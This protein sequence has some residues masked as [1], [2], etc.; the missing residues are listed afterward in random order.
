MCH[1]RNTLN[2]LRN[3]ST[4]RK[5]YTFSLNKKKKRKK[6]NLKLMFQLDNKEI[7]IGTHLVSVNV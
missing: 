1:V 2:P 5:Q 4:N 6:K 3:L 7:D